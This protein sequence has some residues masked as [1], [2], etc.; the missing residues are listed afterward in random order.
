PMLDTTIPASNTILD[1]IDTV[2]W[3]GSLDP[4]AIDDVGRG[5]ERLYGHASAAFRADPRLWLQVVHPEDRPRV[6]ARQDALRSQ[7]TSA[8]EYRIVRP[9]G[10][11]RWVLDR[12]WL[13]RDPTSGLERVHG[14]AIDV[15]AHLQADQELVAWTRRLEAVHAVAVEIT[16]ERDLTALLDLVIE[17]AVA[18]TGA[19]R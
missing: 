1:S 17:R 7:G 3:S 12:A 9:D 13:V 14:I 15:T 16:R 4:F 18:L 8:T 10:S 6:A 2:V 19:V 11:L 5:A